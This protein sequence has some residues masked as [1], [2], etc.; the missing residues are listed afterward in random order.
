MSDA[1]VIWYSYSVCTDHY[2]DIGCKPWHQKCFNF[3][4]EWMKLQWKLELLTPVNPR[5][6]G[7]L[8]FHPRRHHNTSFTMSCPNTQT[9]LASD[10]AISPQSLLG[11]IECSLLSQRHHRRAITPT[12]SFKLG[13]E[14][15]PRTR[16]SLWQPTDSPF[17]LHQPL[18][19]SRSTISSAGNDDFSQKEQ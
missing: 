13:L 19:F 14:L 9:H 18:W 2:L 15:R 8:C 17:T 12:D 10:L 16:G 1:P 6:C 7:P 4:H 11:L 5:T 3:T